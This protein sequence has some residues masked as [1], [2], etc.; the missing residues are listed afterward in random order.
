MKIH[1]HD[2]GVC[3]WS[4][5]PRDTADLISKIKELG[6]SHVQLAM[7]GLS[8]EDLRDRARQ[9]RSAGIDITSGMIGF[10]GEDYASIAIIRQ[11]GGYLPDEQWPARKET[12]E[13]IAALGKEL[14]FTKISTHI[15]FVPVSSDPKYKV[16]LER[17]GH[18]ADVFAANG[19]ELL[20]ESGQEHAPELLQFLNDLARKNV[21]VNFDPANMI[22]Y[23]AGDPV[24]AVQTLGRHIAQVHIKDA[25]LSTRPAVMWGAEVAFGSGQVPHAAFL[26]AL[27]NVGYQG[28]LVIEREAGEQRMR[29]VAFAI[30]TLGAIEV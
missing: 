24:E 13:H 16:M 11:T 7:G 21:R 8:D 18:V 4:I 23:G 19:L 2:I 12:S 27:H 1:G 29:D 14:G 20:M 30:E 22:L 25:T 10:P 28:P 6:L 3:S 9:V 26:E 5:Q 17:V 15:G